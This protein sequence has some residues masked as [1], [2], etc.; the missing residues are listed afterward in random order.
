MNKR[1]LAGLMVP[2]AIGMLA[3]G[4][5]MHTPGHTNA[6]ASTPPPPPTFV[7]T[8]I[9][10]PPPPPTPTPT[11]TPIPTATPIP[12]NTPLPTA[13]ATPPPQVGAPARIVASTSVQRQGNIA[14]VRW[15]MAFQLGIKGFRIYVGNKQLT[16]SMIRPHHSP[17]YSVRVPWVRNGHYVLRVFFKNGHSQ[18]ITIHS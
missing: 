11:H 16:K 1:L 8:P 6:A 18:R 15:H 13:T 2:V 9:G 12:T 10:S 7:P 14:L 3:V 17:N 4:G 5:A